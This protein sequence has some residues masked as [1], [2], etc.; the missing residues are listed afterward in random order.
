MGWP[1]WMQL[2]QLPP[3]GKLVA[4]VK[5]RRQDRLLGLGLA[6]GMR[7]ALGIGLALGLCCPR[8]WAFD[9]IMQGLAL[10][11]ALAF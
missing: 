3:L 11:L 5:S 9:L 7:L 8:P 6:L 1:S 4:P 2:H 10:A